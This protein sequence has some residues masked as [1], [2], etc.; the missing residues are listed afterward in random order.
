MRT[1]TENLREH[2]LTQAGYFIKRPIPSLDL[3]RETEWSDEFAA[4]MRNRLIMGVFRY[5]TQEQQ[6][7]KKIDRIGSLRRRLNDYERTGNLEHMVDFAAIAMAEFIHP[8]HE[9][10]HF[11]ALDDVEHAEVSDA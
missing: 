10:A 2:A 11:G 5:G 9:L 6:A 3:L 8:M 4:L 1:V 7:K